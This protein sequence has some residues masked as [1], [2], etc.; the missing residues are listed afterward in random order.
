IDDFL[1]SL[2]EFLPG[3]FRLRLSLS[4][5]RDSIKEMHFPSSREDWKAARHRLAFDEF[6]LLQA[7]LALRR[8]RT[9]E[10]AGTAPSLPPGKL[11]RKCL[12]ELLPFP[13]TPGQRK[14]VDEIFGDMSRS[15]PMNRLLQG[16]VGSGKTAV[17]LLALLA[18]LDGGCQGAFLAP[19]EIL[20][21]SIFRDL[22]RLWGRSGRN[23]PSSPVL[24]LR[25]KKKGSR[26][27][28]KPGK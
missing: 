15:V 22:P 4:G 14:A 24:S 12:N 17:G 8:R 18:A 25:R 1:P 6:F 27:A 23:A 7:G 2:E 9:G 3:D 19:T 11:V 16:D 20:A 5:I 10:D 21:T 28:W 13:L 26:R